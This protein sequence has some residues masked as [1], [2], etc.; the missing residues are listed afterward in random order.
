MN[1]DDAS[2]WSGAR[3]SGSRWQLRLMRRVALSAPAFVVD[4]MLWVISL[5]YALNTRRLATRGSILY[6]RKVL[7]REPTLSDRH[8][9]ARTFAHVF[10]DRVRLLS[11]GVNAFTVT[12]QREHLIGD[13]HA[14]GKGAVL[15]GAH[16]G[17][18][19]ALRAFDRVLPGL[20][21][22]Y[23]MFPDHAPH[24]TELL[25]EINPD[26]A[27]K[28]ISL[29]NG[30]HAMMEVYEALERGEFVAFLGDRM[31]NAA[32][33]AKVS[34]QFL[35]SAIDVPTS[36]Y[37]AAMAAKVPLIL[38]TAPRLGKDRYEVEF[39]L[40]HD[41]S[42]VQRAE[43]QTIIEGLARRYVETLETL[44]RRHP[45]NWFNFFDIWSK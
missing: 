2:D 30:Q 31:P 38:C 28:V 20:N 41:G 7:G 34:A 29:A 12:S 11:D 33:R 21:V 9:H 16:F 27:D 18:F 39:T 3:E 6:L 1:A 4:P 25:R 5:C 45:Y 26:V 13:L 22:R 10:L 15:I 43:R 44:C 36:P 8:R 17:S 24:S 37:I 32:I 23:L 14:A 35:G 40:F 42:P 19:E